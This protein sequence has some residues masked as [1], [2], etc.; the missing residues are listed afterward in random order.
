MA[1]LTREAASV[2]FA[3]PL[4]IRLLSTRN[5]RAMGTMAAAGLPFV[6]VYLLYNSALTG[7]P[8]LLPRMLFDPS[9]HFGFGDGVGFHT[10]HTLAAGLVNTDELLTILQLDLF[11]WPP[12][13]TLGLLAVPFL[14][15]RPRLWDYLA[16][17]GFLACVVVYVG[18][19]YHGIALGP[20]YYFEAV[21]WLLLLAGR[22]AHALAEFV[23]SRVAVAVVLG[24][25]SLNTL[26]FYLPLEIERRVDLSG[27]PGGRTFR[28]AFVEPGLLGP[29]LDGV[30]TP[31]L[32]LTADW[33]LFNT[34]LAPLNCP[35]LPECPVLFA[36][37]T[38]RADEN[39]LRAQFPGRTVLRTSDDNG[40]IS[41]TPA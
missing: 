23:Y 12:F 25:L 30:P 13:F 4:G 10:R 2:L 28:L 37:A 29:Q 16:A 5:T 15:G 31:S 40:R 33:W 35:N 39:A 26:F 14:V 17:L 36:L 6:A 8:T 38:N 3:I 18:Y 32:V 19:F 22:G 34:G 21:P 24:L 9:D 7:S 1:F 41:L 11:G 20:R 27:L